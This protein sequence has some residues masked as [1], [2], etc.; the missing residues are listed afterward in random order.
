MAIPIPSVQTP[1]GENFLYHLQAPQKNLLNYLDYLATQGDIVQLGFG[2]FKAVYLN[3]PDYIQQVLVTQASKFQKPQNI[4]KA[5]ADLLGYNL[6]SAD[7]DVWRV[8]RKSL[9]PAFHM[10][11]ISEYLDL[12]V[13]YTDEMIKQW[14]DNDPVNIPDLMMDLTLGI[15][16]KALFDVDLRDDAI[17]QQIIRFI[18]LFNERII[19][20]MPLPL[21]IPTQANREIKE[22]VQIAK[23]YLLPVIEERRKSGDDR[24]DL[25]SMLLIAQREDDTGILTDAQ[26]F[27][28]I[29]NIFAAGYEGVAHTMAFTLYLISQHPLVETK[30]IEELDAEIGKRRL[31]IDDLEHLPYLEQV[32]KEA[33]RLYPVTA[34][35]GRQ[36]IED[37]QVGDYV[38]P[39]GAQILIAPWTLHHRADI[40]PVPERFDPDRFSP[41]RADAIPKHAYIPF[42]TG[43][44]ICLGSAFTMLQLWSNL[45]TIYQ[46]YRLSTEPNHKLE[47]TWRFNTRPANGLP[48]IAHDRSIQ[49]EPTHHTR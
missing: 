3:H 21:W 2:G 39:K 11:R 20:P 26:V 33:M 7:G 16:T 46:R 5:V 42:S 9:Q 19:N 4:K 32:I 35:V 36:A 40:F 44:R 22:C 15:T 23:D 29:S 12:M 34:L 18:E 6:F 14:S 48:M 8:L 49:S 31:R 25:L 45:A 17:G 27:N 30:L 37:V 10:Q 24:G 13:D 47:L 41:E 28:E 38:I 1:D 43:P